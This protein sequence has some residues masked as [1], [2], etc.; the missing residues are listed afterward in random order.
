MTGSPKA[1]LRLK[2]KKTLSS[3]N[4]SALLEKSEK[5]NHHLKKWLDELSNKHFPKSIVVGGYAPMKGEVD[6]TKLEQSFAS[7]YPGFFAGVMAFRKSRLSDLKR[8]KDFGVSLLTPT[9]DHEVVTPDVLI[10]PGIA[11]TKKGERLGRGKGFYDRYL[12]GYKGLKV[13]VC[14]KE[15]LRDAIPVEEHD[16][17]MNYVIS[18]EGIFTLE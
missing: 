12:S 4:E 6:W 5:V 14:F 3:L 10:V 17:V 2:V 1:S 13:G 16:V 9:L 15:Q 8:T 11:F 7:A 18:E